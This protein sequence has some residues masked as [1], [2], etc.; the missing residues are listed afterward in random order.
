MNMREYY[1]EQGYLCP[2]CEVK[3]KNADGMGLI[4]CALSH[5]Y[6]IPLANTFAAGVM[7]ACKIEDWNKCQLNTE[8]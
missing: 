1:F 2:N 4:M 6:P 8:K 5:K 7:K 3:W